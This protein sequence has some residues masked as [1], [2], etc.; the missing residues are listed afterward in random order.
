MSHESD[1]FTMKLTP[2]QQEQVRQATGVMG[3]TL[4]LSIRE[5][6]DRIAPSMARPHVSG[7]RIP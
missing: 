6:E 7:N 3:D 4:E 5:L 2:E 1:R